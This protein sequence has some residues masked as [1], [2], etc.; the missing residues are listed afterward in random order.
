MQTV[1]PRF[2]SDNFIKERYSGNITAVALFLDFSGFTTMTERLMK[3]G[4]EGAEVLAYTINNVFNSVIDIVY[5]SGGFIATFAGDAF[6]AI[7]PDGHPESVIACSAA[8]RDIVYRMSPQMTKFGE[9][10][11]S[12]KI[13]LSYGEVEWGIIGPEGHK[14]YFFRGK[15]VKGCIL[16]ET[17]CKKMDIVMDNSIFDLLSV[18]DIETR[19]LKGG[20]HRFVRF[21]KD[22]DFEFQ[23]NEAVIKGIADDVL[24]N[25]FPS[26]MFK[27]RHAGEFRNIVSIFISFD[28]LLTSEELNSIVTMIIKKCDKMGGYFN[29]IDFGDKGGVM[30]VIFGAPVYYEN[31]YKRATEFILKVVST[32]K[33]IIRAGISSGIAFS[34]FTG[35]SI[36]SEYT[37]LS[38]K[39]NQAARLMEMAERGQIFASGE[40]IGFLNKNYQLIFIGNK[41]LKGRRKQLPVYEL[42]DHK[43]N[44]ESSIYHGKMVG[45][46][47][48]LSILDKISQTLFSGIFAGIIIIY[49]EAGI[50]K[51]RLVYEFAKKLKSMCR[52]IIFQFDS[53]QKTG[54]NPFKL[55]LSDYFQHSERNTLDQNK[56]YFNINFKS[57][58]N[59]LN[60]IRDRRKASIIK[61]LKKLRSF[62]AAQLG[63]D[64]KNSL[65]SRMRNDPK[66]V[67]ENTIYAYK[68]L[69]KALSLIKPVL[70]QFE[71]LHWI[72]DSSQE[73]L[74]TLC[75]NISS[76][77]IIIIATSRYYDDGSKPAISADTEIK[78]YEVE[79]SKLS[80][81]E[82]KTL[83]NH[84]LG[85]KAKP[86]MI[87]YIIERSENNPFYI[88]Q[89]IEYM[90]E[91]RL[92][93][94]IGN[95]LVYN[96]SEI[97]VPNNIY[98]I[99]MSRIDNLEN[100]LKDIIKLAAVV[101]KE[102][103]IDLLLYLI[104]LLHLALEKE[105]A[106]Y[107]LENIEYRRIWYKISQLRYL[108]KHSLIQKA[109]Y[110]T[111]LKATLRELHDYVA[112][113]LE[114][115]YPGEEERYYEIAYHF[116]KAEKTKMALEYYERA[117]YY[118]KNKYENIKALNCFNLILSMNK[119]KN[120]LKHF[121]SLAE[122]LDINM[123]I[124][125][126][127]E[128]R[129][130]CERSMK[131]ARE[132]GYKRF[133]N[134]FFM[135]Y[136]WLISK[137]GE[138]VQSLEI[139][140]QILEYSK[141][142]G[143]KKLM[144][145]ILI[146]IGN[147]YIKQ[148]KF[149]KALELLSRQKKIL[150][151]YGDLKELTKLYY[152]MGVAHMR[153]GKF[154]EAFECFEYSQR[155]S[156]EIGDDVSICDC[157]VN[158]GIIYR[159]QGDFN[160]AMDYFNRALS[161]AEKIGFKKGL[162]T[163]YGNMAILHFTTG[164][165]NKAA[166]YYNKEKAIAEEIGDK[167]EM[168]TIA[169]NLGALYY[170][171]GNIKKAMRY[172]EKQKLISQKIGD[173]MNYGIALV[174]IGLIYMD[175][176]RYEEATELFEKRKKICE[177]N[178][179]MPGLCHVLGNLGILYV[180]RG[181][182]DKAMDIYEKTMKIA[183][184]LNDQRT[185]SITIAN[186]SG[187]YQKK[188]EY[189]KALLYINKAITIANKL[190]VKFYICYNLINKAE[191]L[192]NQ[193][194]Y[195][196]LDKLLKK[197]KTIAEQIKDKY[198]TFLVKVLEYRL[199]SFQDSRNAVEHFYEMLDNEKNP[200]CKSKIHYE[201]WRINKSENSR[202]TALR[203]FKRLYKK[204]PDYDYKLAIMELSSFISG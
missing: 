158:R 121:E 91:N 78:Q 123:L 18:N 66:I 102:I 31:I 81:K 9:F 202:K 12:I 22:F 156:S 61:E 197:A 171:L 79:I 189:K 82:S 183:E 45:R 44:V 162:S 187:I 86:E 11:I 19:R 168:N 169:G 151:E 188:F 70:M 165:Y 154:L 111:L 203:I 93:K 141:V 137:Q 69:F 113:A 147:M 5:S 15:A 51:S 193:R 48:H 34:G 72:D 96:M 128:S 88:E 192:F 52:L 181:E 125:N 124:G 184:N 180:N 138:F 98:S 167:N 114:T 201:I 108:F 146:N 144:S 27:S 174:N 106:I 149:N 30:L 3:K 75:R 105:D 182:L 172:Y 85:I 90:K 68:E 94:K 135:K 53:I 84:Y 130:I 129:K 178:G 32:V 198:L 185:I 39:V 148:G 112:M 95:N 176:G 194:N 97:L 190:K 37:V 14:T 173:I 104:E 74:R 160:K 16:S 136:A 103:D 63:L 117:G 101:G 62:L 10:L 100:D 153:Q 195:G 21:T 1:I 150:D 110:G 33:K 139:Y 133:Y 50:G 166:H 175:Q 99:I 115:K 25:F 87:D 24:S 132:M 26:F 116:H 159:D 89:I 38:D 54:F 186:I 127:D 64:F 161:H 43:L 80:N 142:A 83:I 126:L 73:L 67:Y 131:E 4:E 59:E 204:K 42:L 143:D 57:L 199:L 28:E 77:P 71:D 6:T 41:K 157:L 109:V 58:I 152:N 29:R 65:Y 134:I 40:M 119:K 200:N 36:R 170:Q 191:I 145:V 60:S 164:K 20:Y 49:G 17:K 177:E 140:N 35:S 47:E 118:L 8:I 122:I 92:I 179:D 23:K 46:K 7:F 196:N 13:G 155:L 55:F 76:Y 163:A 2:I 120:I 56:S 107:R